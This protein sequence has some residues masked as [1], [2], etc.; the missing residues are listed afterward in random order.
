MKVE[1]PKRRID[2]TCR[3]QEAWETPQPARKR[4]NPFTQ[5]L[6]G[7]FMDGN[8]DGIGALARE[9]Q[10]IEAE[11]RLAGGD[12][13]H[14][15]LEDCSDLSDIIDEI[16]EVNSK[17]G[18][19]EHAAFEAK[20]KF[21]RKIR[22]KAKD[23]K[24]FEQHLVQEYDNKHITLEHGKRMVSIIKLLRSKKV[25]DARREAKEFYEFLEMGARLAIIDDLLLK[26]RAQ[27]ERAKRGAEARLSDLEWLEKEPPVDESKVKRHEE[28]SQLNVEL[29][30][31]WAA[32]VQALKSMP[33]CVLLGKMKGDELGKIGFPEIAEKDAEQLVVFL[34][35]H[36]LS[37]KSAEELHEMAGQSEQKL[38]HS[39]MDLALFR[40][41]VVARKAFLFEIMTFSADSC[42]L[43]AGSPALAYFSENDEGAR[44]LVE[45]LSEL[46]KS[47]GE[48]NAEWERARRINERREALSG[49][50]KASVDNELQKLRTLVDVLDGKAAP[51]DAE[52]SEKEKGIVGALLKLLG[53]KK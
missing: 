43:T 19:K 2:P 10:Q 7:N 21:S 15:L 33:L 23:L 8:V 18:E 42:A 14:F 29:L 20:V 3:F 48:D 9:K 6:G 50:D 49:A 26:K 32:H 28:L 1:L 40:Q 30:K 27:I 34:Q 16:D 11:L 5:K 38:R 52:K 37:A 51:T 13:F 45:R 41:E 22:R 53:G 47:N 46:E 17:M 25:D 39:G 4:F 35:K 31:T 24:N 12:D 44:K 36:G